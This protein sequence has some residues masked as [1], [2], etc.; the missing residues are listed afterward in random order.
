MNVDKETFLKDV[1]TLKARRVIVLD[2]E[3][4]DNTGVAKT[5]LSAYLN[6]EHSLNPSKTF[7]KKFYEI[8]GPCIYQTGPAHY[9]LSTFN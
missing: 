8:Y 6:S 2:K 1:A 4:V 3:I 7:L 5:A 9:P